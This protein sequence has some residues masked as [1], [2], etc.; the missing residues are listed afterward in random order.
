MLGACHVKPH[1]PDYGCSAQKDFV[2]R[3][4]STYILLHEGTPVIQVL[5]DHEV[6]EDHPDG[7]LSG[8]AV[9]LMGAAP[10]G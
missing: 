5:V 1:E 8:W 6:E 9:Y 4:I 7:P 3:H 10:G 2:G